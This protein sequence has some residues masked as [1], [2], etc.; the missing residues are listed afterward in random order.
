MSNS[1][2]REKKYEE[3]LKF[4]E[5]LVKKGKA[6]EILAYYL[7]EDWEKSEEIMSLDLLTFKLIN[8]IEGT[9]NRRNI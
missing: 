5:M 8:E 4:A 9:Y 1:I 2:D 6:E 3:A 7:A